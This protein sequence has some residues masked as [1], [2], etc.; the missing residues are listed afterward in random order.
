MSGRF[1]GEPVGDR[2]GTGSRCGGCGRRKPAAA[3]LTD[4]RHQQR[5]YAGPKHL[6]NVLRGAERIKHTEVDRHGPGMALRL[7][8]RWRDKGGGYNSECRGG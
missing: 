8:C 6:R 5:A 4:I 3:V 1:E 2:Y 7:G